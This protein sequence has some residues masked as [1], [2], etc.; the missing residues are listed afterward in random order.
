MFWA[1]E[2]WMLSGVVPRYNIELDKIEILPEDQHISI[3]VDLLQGTLDK[4]K[5]VYSPCTYTKPTYFPP[6]QPPASKV[7]E[8]KKNES[9]GGT[10]SYKGST[11][12][13][14]GICGATKKDRHEVSYITVHQDEFPLRDVRWY[15]DHTINPIDW[16]G[17]EI[18]CELYTF[19]IAAQDGVWHR[20]NPNSVT[21]LDNDPVVD[22]NPK[23]LHTCMWCAAPIF[24][25]DA[26]AVVKE[27]FTTGDDKLCKDCM[28]DSEITEYVTVVTHVS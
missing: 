16:I 19:R 25:G 21:L 24:E 7:V 17:E 5:M 20:V 4:P 23:M 10:T 27:Q 11:E 26:Y 8:V 3:A 22:T 14:T 2:Y 9:T 13:I 1:S 28:S 15:Y 6:A 12:K 18:E